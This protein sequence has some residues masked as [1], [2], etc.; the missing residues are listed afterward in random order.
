MVIA[1]PATAQASVQPVAL[2]V[3]VAQISSRVNNIKSF[4]LP[5]LAFSLFLFLFLL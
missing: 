4:I 5:K 1:D 3:V 2:A